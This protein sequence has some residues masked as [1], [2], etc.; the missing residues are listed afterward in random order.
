MAEKLDEKIKHKERTKIMQPQKTDD[1]IR[2]SGMVGISC[3]KCVKYHI[4][5]KQC[6]SVNL[7]II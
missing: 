7:S 1:D 5:V 2:W 3:F 4:E 6:W